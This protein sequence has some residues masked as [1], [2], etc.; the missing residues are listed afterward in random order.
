VSREPGESIEDLE[1]VGVSVTDLV[2]IVTLRRPPVNALSAPMMREIARVFTALGRGTSAA[3]AILT[4]SGDRVFCAGADIGESD[5]RY[6]RRELLPTESVAD[7][8]DPGEVVRDCFFSI[9]GGTLPVIAAVNGAAVGAGVALVAS[10]DIVI[11]SSNAVFALPEI[12]VGVL[13]GGRHMQRLAGPF[14]AREM[15]FTGR[16]MTAAELA[17]HG[18]VSQVVSPDEL[19]GAARSVARVIAGKSPLALRLAKQAM[20]RVEHLPLEDGYR[21]EQDYTARVSRF[22]D[23]LEAR[24]ARLE[25]RSP[26]W[27]W[28]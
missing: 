17:G 27:N 10:C 4:A 12:D 5:R 21:L 7:L 6:N 11:A 22:D 28:R 16:R 20:N 26:S 25:K 13:G 23:A 24:S 9:S 2:A 18:S 8:V 19:S 3:V 15:M 14:K 1:F